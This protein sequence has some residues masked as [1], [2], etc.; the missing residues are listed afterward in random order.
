[1]I[2]ERL[3]I[4]EYKNVKPVELADLSAALTAIGDQ[5]KRFV[6]D[7][8][9]IESEAR[10][11]VHEMRAGSII[12]ELVPMAEAVSY[13]YDH[14]ELIAGFLAQW[15]DMTT[16]VLHLTDDAKSI[17]KPTLRNIRAANEVTAKDGG[18]QQNFIAQD[19]GVI[20]NQFNIGSE[21][22]AA[23]SHNATHLLKSEFPNEER[24]SNEPMTLHQLRDGKRGDFGFIDRYSTKAL[25]LTFAGDTTKHG[26]LHHSGN[27]FDHI[28]W[29]EGVVKTVGGRPVGYHITGLIDTTDKE[30]G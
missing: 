18:A 5:F 15:Q 11:Y 24:F 4:I 12:A 2:S 16:A 23:I 1:M 21:A 14:K 19:G 3:M 25:K 7:Q 27:P 13:I 10:L 8:G 28:F 20:I 9:G 22:A 6:T 26:V 17:D 30:V 29:V